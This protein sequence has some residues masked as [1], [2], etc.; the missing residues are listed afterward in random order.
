MPIP[1][2]QYQGPMSQPQ[3][4]AQ[5][6]SPN[7]QQS[8][9][10]DVSKVSQTVNTTASQNP[11]LV[12][13]VM[14]KPRNATS[15]EDVV[16][17]QQHVT[18]H[19]LKKEVHKFR[20]NQNNVQRAL[21]EI[22][23][24]N[25]R[26][27]INELVEAQN[28]IL[29]EHNP[30]MEYRIV[31]I[32]NKF[33]ERAYLTHREKQLVRVDII[34]EA[35]DSGF[36]APKTGAGTATSGFAPA[37]QQMPQQR[38]QPQHQHPPPPPPPPPP[39]MGPPPLNVVAPPPVESYR[40]PPLPQGSAHM[41]MHSQQAQPPPPPPPPSG[42][43]HGQVPMDRPAP[44]GPPPP[45][46]ANGRVHTA[47]PGP[48]VRQPPMQHYPS[49][50]PSGMPG[51][52]PQSTQM[53]IPAP[54]MR[55]SQANE[56][57]DPELLR[58]QKAKRMS[59]TDVSS[60]VSWESDVSW[61]DESEGSSFVDIDN[62]M[63]VNTGH[64][65]RGRSMK[66]PQKIPV[67]RL[68]SKS[69]RRN[70]S[71]GRSQSQSHPRRVVHEKHTQRPGQ[72]HRDGSDIDDG[73]FGRRTPDG[74]GSSSP[75][76]PAN[77]H[78][79][80]NTNNMAEDRTRS[81]NASPVNPYNEKKGKKKPGK[82]YASHDDVSDGSWENASGTESYYTTSVHT[83]DDGIWDT[84]SGRRPLHREP[85]RRKPSGAAFQRPADPYE[86]QSRS[87]TQHNP[88]MR[89]A[90]RQRYPREPAEEQLTASHTIPRHP[91][92]RDRDRDRNND[93]TPPFFSDPP[94]RPDL[95]HR[96]HTTPSMPMPRH[97]TPPLPIPP[98]PARP[99]SFAQDPRDTQAYPVRHH[100]AD[101]DAEP[102]DEQITLRDL[103]TA[104]EW[105]RQNN[106]KGR[107]EAGYGYA[108]TAAAAA[109]NE[110]GNPRGNRTRRV[111][112]DDDEWDDR[113]RTDMYDGYVR[114]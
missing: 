31:S 34:L 90:Q 16:P 53:P 10:Q 109:A 51:S 13:F 57:L 88:D 35:E 105:A 55:P 101:M 104:L 43:R 100:G 1:Q 30:A 76:A 58:R 28:A 112:Y 86:P 49:Q 24:P 77:I 47:T 70:G 26:R 59:Y 106:E 14:E 84:P 78:I 4:T 9:D 80:M 52:Y 11:L 33:R 21:K 96:H 66:Q 41:P 102:Q 42:A 39:G 17:E 54:G 38:P 82:L 75:Q 62:D 46:P 64:H 95:P 110:S 25:C 48:H 3:S 5:R 92:M 94:S 18:V 97:T 74:S 8:F 36:Q 63:R 98:K 12:A 37:Q 81:G 60:G 85:S 87:Y 50:G 68:R 20:R 83:A 89:S 27:I 40:Q 6:Q 29:T 2:A 108:A 44:T 114:Y 56:N 111:V 22:S 69:Q 79:H 32:V 91:S 93:Y 99:F 23:S 113:R 61:E 45:P 15:W 19:D 67:H 72:K 103:H 65:R 73:Y 107:R 71:R 7:A